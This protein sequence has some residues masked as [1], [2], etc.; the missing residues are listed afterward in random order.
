MKNDVKCFLENF[1]ILFFI[2]PRLSPTVLNVA[3]KPKIISKDLMTVKID[4]M[5]S[6]TIMFVHVFVG[7][8]YAAP[9]TLYLLLI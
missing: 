7:G 9:E 5:C 1:Y 4:G 8:P 6:R 2:I 3:E